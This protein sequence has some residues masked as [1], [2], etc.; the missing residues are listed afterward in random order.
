LTNSPFLLPRGGTPVKIKARYFPENGQ[1][2]IVHDPR[3]S[4]RQIIEAKPRDAL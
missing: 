2:N 3:K 1:Q 4:A